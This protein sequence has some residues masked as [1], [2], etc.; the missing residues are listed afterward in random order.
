M[1]SSLEILVITLAAIIFIVGIPFLV[2]WA[3]ENM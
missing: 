2:A 1:L 3:F